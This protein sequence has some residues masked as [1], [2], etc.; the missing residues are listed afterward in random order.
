MVR[1]SQHGVCVLCGGVAGGA[2][3][4]PITIPRVLLI[5]NGI[6]ALNFNPFVEGKGVGNLC[7]GKSTLLRRS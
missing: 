7:D 5:G 1:G 2:S 3:L 6:V 4:D